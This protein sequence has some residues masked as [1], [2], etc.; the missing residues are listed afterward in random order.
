M[1]ITEFIST[2]SFVGLS[3]AYF[4]LYLCYLRQRIVIN[5]LIWALS[6]FAMVGEMATSKS[7]NWHGEGVK[8]EMLARLRAIDFRDA[9]NA[10]T[11]ATESSNS[12]PDLASQTPSA[13]DPA[14]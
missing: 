3:I 13:S 7:G 12:P 8:R 14:P 11:N 4:A 2:T 6:P 10:V 5:K 9:A 1:T